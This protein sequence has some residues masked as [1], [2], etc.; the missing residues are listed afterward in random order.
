MTVRTIV[1]LFV[2]LVGLSALTVSVVIARGG[3][4]P[5]NEIQSLSSTFTYQGRLTNSSGPVT[6]ICDFQFRL[7]DSEMAGTQI[8]DTAT[9][10]DVNVSNGLF[11]VQ[12]DFGGEA[13]K[14]SD[15]FLEIE[16]RCPAGEGLF[17]S[18]PRQPITPTPYAVHAFSSSSVPWD[19]V[20]DVPPDIADG[21]NDSLGDLIC[22]VG[23]IPRWDGTNWICGDAVAIISIIDP[24]RNVGEFNSITIGADG[25][26]LISYLD[27]DNGDLKVAHCKNITCNHA[28]I[29][30]LDDASDANTSI[31]IG[32]DGL[33]LISYR[34]GNDLVV[35]HCSNVA[36]TSASKSPIH[37]T[38]NGIGF[39]SISLGADD[40]GIV[41][42][43]NNDT[44]KLTVAHCENVLCDRA[45]IIPVDDASDVGQRISITVGGDGLPL[46]SYRGKSVGLKTAHCNELT[47]TN[48]TITTHEFSQAAG[49][50]TSI[51]AG[52]DGFGLISYHSPNEGALK[53]AHCD[54]FDCSSASINSLD[55]GDVGHFASITLGTDNLGFISYFDNNLNALKTAHCDDTV[56]S[57]ASI[58]VI[59]TNA[60]GR[61]ISVTIGSDSLGLMAYKGVSN[62]SLLVAHCASVIFCK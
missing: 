28:D 61:E 50:Y 26:G 49:Q 62:N 19:G 16:V 27:R 6:D 43:L 14:G 22:E 58:A 38:I 30:R 21:D 37:T 13:F 2:L 33:G 10:S 57:S 11:T 12:L 23:Q 17:T 18:L 41:A 24:N 29:T 59:D 35:A 52:A 53:V 56:C 51:V 54:N 1:P 9:K 5:N 44:D 3:A 36:C 31:T 48:A 4:S 8:G 40:L 15:R 45:T 60:V 7:F 32:S 20:A 39:G 46:I 25:L 55:L 34:R 47:C 42:Y